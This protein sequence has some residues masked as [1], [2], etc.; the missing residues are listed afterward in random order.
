M[1]IKEAD[2]FTSNLIFQW[3]IP[4]IIDNKDQEYLFKE[5]L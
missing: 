2:I 1:V 3:F 5:K 4:N